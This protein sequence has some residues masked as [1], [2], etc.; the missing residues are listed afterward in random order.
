M[1]QGLSYV[2]HFLFIF[3]DFE[4]TRELIFTQ[5]YLFSPLCAR[6]RLK[7]K[8]NKQH[9]HTYFRK[10]AGIVA[11]VLLLTHSLAVVYSR[12]YIISVFIRFSSCP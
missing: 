10:P 1:F 9:N 6:G 12:R 5:K 8:K 3:L 4:R 2:L 7:V 11:Y